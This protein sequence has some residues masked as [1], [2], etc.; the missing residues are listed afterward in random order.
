MTGKELVEVRCLRKSEPLPNRA[1][2]VIGVSEE[3]FCFQHYPLVEDTLCGEAGDLLAR[4]RDRPLRVAEIAYEPAS[5]SALP[6]AAFDRSAIGNVGIG[7]IGRAYG[8]RPPLEEIDEP[9]EHVADQTHRRWVGPETALFAHQHRKQILHAVRRSSIEVDVGGVPRKPVGYPA[10]LGSSDHDLRVERVALM[11]LMN[12]ARADEQHAARNELDELEIERV[13]PRASSDDQDHPE[14]GALCR[15]E[16]VGTH[17]FENFTIVDN[18]DRQARANRAG[19]A[20]VEY[21]SGHV[22][23]SIA[24]LRDEAARSG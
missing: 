22:H 8:R 17:S 19:K 12:L 5:V 6:K 16:M 3:A 7:Q 24:H 18:L 9:G 21:L 14:G 1:D 10:Q 13:G 23:H 15:G 2:R 20:N 11:P 4:P